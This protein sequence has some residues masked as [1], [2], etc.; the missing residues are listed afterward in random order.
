MAGGGGP[1]ALGRPRTSTPAGLTHL[2]L[3][4]LLRCRQGRQRPEEAPP[5]DAPPLSVTRPAPRT[6][7]LSSLAG[8]LERAAST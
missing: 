8:V 3:R 7:L 5:Y 4:R 2:P 6:G 1:R